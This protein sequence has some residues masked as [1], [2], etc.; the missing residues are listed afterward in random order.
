MYL[1]LVIPRFICNAKLGSVPLSCLYLGLRS[2]DAT[3]TINCV[4]AQG[5]GFEWITWHSYVGLLRYSLN[6]ASYM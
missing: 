5:S 6:V 2:M 1:R 4:H 3:I